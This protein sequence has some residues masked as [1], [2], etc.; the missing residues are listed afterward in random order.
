[1]KSS[2]LF[3]TL[4]YMVCA[5]I[6]FPICT[7]IAH[8]SPQNTPAALS[9]KIY[10]IEPTELFGVSRLKQVPLISDMQ[11]IDLSIVPQMEAM[12][13][14]HVNDTIN[15]QSIEKIKSLSVQLPR[16]QLQKLADA[17]TSLFDLRMRYDVAIDDLPIVIF[18]QDKNF[19]LYKGNDA[20]QGFLLW[21]KSKK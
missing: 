14:A 16:L 4:F 3:Y 12:F 5:A 2:K 17:H 13:S 7:D 6:V 15:Q 11:I 19:Y 18:E 10:S 8:A 20:Y 1:M 9:V 21:Q